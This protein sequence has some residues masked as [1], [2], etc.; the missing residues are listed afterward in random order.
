MGSKKL[1]LYRTNP[2]NQIKKI[3]AK[4]ENIKLD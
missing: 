4:N 1:S 2:Q 3:N